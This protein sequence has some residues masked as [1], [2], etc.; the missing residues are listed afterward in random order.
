LGASFASASFVTSPLTVCS[1][2]QNIR[3]HSHEF[4]DG[5]L[6]W[7]YMPGTPLCELVKQYAL[8]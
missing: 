1:V 4:R 3:K 7:L 8:F 5:L 2:F 6:D